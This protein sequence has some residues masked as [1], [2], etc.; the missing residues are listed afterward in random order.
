MIRALVTGG[1][2][3]IGAAVCKRLAADGRHVYVY[4]RRDVPLRVSK[5]D[6]AT[7]TRRTSRWNAIRSSPFTGRSNFGS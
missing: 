1:S 4:R 7:G 3:G 2:G 6:V 5:L